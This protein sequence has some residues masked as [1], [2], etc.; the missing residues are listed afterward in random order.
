MSFETMQEKINQRGR[1]EAHRANLK[2]A[3]AHG[4]SDKH[5]RE[6]IR[7]CDEA[8]QELEGFRQYVAG[9]KK[10]SDDAV[11]QHAETCTPL[12]AE[13]DSTAA[14][15]RKVEMRVAINQANEKLETALADHKKTI[16]AAQEEIEFIRGRVGVRIAVEN[17]F[18]GAGPQEQLDRVGVLR[19]VDSWLQVPISEWHSKSKARV[20]SAEFAAE[21]AANGYSADVAHAQRE[22]RHAENIL[23]E[24]KKYS[25]ACAAEIESIRAERLKKLYA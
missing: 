20:I 14:V 8:E 15:S 5:Y 18:V 2:D 21:K 12:Q 9:I 7:K 10:Q 17:A 22:A 6:Q 4:C 19:V 13:M 25:R 23:L 24:L 3:A 1:H 11:Q 16:A